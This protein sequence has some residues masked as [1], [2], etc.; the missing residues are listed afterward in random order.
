MIDFPYVIGCPSWNEPG[1]RDLLAGDPSDDLLCRYC[2]TFNGVEGNTTFH[3]RPSLSTVMRWAERMPATFRFC[4]KFNR[5]ISHNGDLRD[6]FEETQSFLDLLRPLGQ[7]LN[8]LWLQLP[9]TFGPNRLAELE[10]WLDAFDHLTLAVEVR[11]LDFYS[12]GEPERALNRLLRGR[13]VERIGFDTR[14]VFQSP[15]TDAYVREAQS[16]KP[17][18]PVRAPAFTNEPQVRFVGSGDLL[19]NDT[20]LS[21]W[22]TKVADWICEGRM[23]HVYLHAPDNRQAAAQAFRFHEQ[24]QALVPGLPDLPTP[25]PQAEQLG[26]L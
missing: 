23:P 5:D 2:A 16:R 18:L 8:P 25:V 4:A 14:A 3:A 20:F 22:V 1:W 21:P 7:R 15:L 12:K 6:R 9:A 13:G 11:H 24:L 19:F 26:L 17:R 10:A